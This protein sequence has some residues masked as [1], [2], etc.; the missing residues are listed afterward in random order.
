MVTLYAS[1]YEAAAKGFYFKS[2]EEYAAKAA[3]LRNS[4]GDPIEEFDIDFIDGERIDVDLSK[5]WGLDQCNFPA[6]LDACDEWDEDD[7]R[8]FIIAVGEC[9]YSFDHDSVKPDDFEVDIYQCESM[10][11]LAE[12]FVDEG[13]FGD[14]PEH[15]TNYIDYDAI[16]RDLAVDYSETRINGETFIYRCG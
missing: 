11:E 7:K 9:G 15:L 5:A 6:F 2:E 8:S 16:A 4:F 14:I 13:L 1:P 12:Q 10:K 3:K